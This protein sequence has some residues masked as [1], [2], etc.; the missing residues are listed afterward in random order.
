MLVVGRA[1][2]TARNRNGV[3]GFTILELLAALAMLA[4]LVAIAV[5]GYQVYI[6]RARE[7]RAL[8]E[9]GELEI[10]VNEFL[11][12]NSAQLPANLAAIGLGGKID[13]WGNA[14]V[15][16]NLSLGGAPRTD[17]N[18]DPINTQY[19]LYSLGPDGA[20]AL[21]LTDGAS[22]DDIIRASDGGFIGVVDDYTRLD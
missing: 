8:A 2:V 12:A 18:G 10:A 20:T 19:D 22:E 16:V 6:E 13:P 5:P 15:Y 21:S 17:Q 1:Q 11:A 14:W 4:I 7:S 3:A 9:L